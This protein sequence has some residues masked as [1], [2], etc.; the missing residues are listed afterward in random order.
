VVPGDALNNSAF[1]STHEYVP[2]RTSTSNFHTTC[3]NSSNHMMADYYLL[4]MRPV[5]ISGFENVSTSV[6]K[7]VTYIEDICSADSES[8]S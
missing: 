6:N 1:R 8:L 5:S 3:G 2:D 4:E 7:G